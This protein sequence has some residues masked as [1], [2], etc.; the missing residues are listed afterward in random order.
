MPVVVRANPY[1][2]RFRK[3]H[4][5][6][7]SKMGKPVSALARPRVWLAFMKKWVGQTF[8]LVLAI[9]AESTLM[10]RRRR[11]VLGNTMIFLNNICC[12]VIQK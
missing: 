12:E 8:S 2:K 5:A 10:R 3:P 9:A 4:Q 1:C 6:L 7:L 11:S